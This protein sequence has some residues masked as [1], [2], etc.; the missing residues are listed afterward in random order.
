MSY[1]RRW[2]IALGA[3]LFGSIALLTAAPTKEE[4][5]VEKYTKQLRTGKDA[6]EKAAALK[7]LGRL[8][9]IQT[10]LT[11]PVVP[12]I[13]KALDDK[14]AG[15][16]GEAAHTL[17]RIDPENKKPV[18]EKLIKMIKEDKDE[19]ARR[20][21]AAGLGAMGPD[22]RDAAETLREAMA[23]AGKKDAAPYQAALLSITGRKK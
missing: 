7:E 15:V 5:E 10:S 14:D 20:G 2:P 18:V 13:L 21:A 4:R 11:K 1:R 22:A 9:A 3:L 19:A 16:R 23:K 6:K 12:D 8:G 17:G